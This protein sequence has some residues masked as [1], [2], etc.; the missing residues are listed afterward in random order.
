MIDFLLEIGVEEFPPAILSSTARELSSKVERLLKSKNIFYRS[1]RLIYT[2][3]RMGIIVLGLPRKQ[4]SKI[5]EIQGPPK[6]VAY[7][8]QDNP[9]RMLTGFLKAHNVKIA[10][11]RTKRTKKGEY[12]FIKK[13]VAGILTEDILYED[14]PPLIRSLEFPKTMRW[15]N[16]PERFPRPVRWIVALLDR[17]PLRF[18]FAGV[19]A[20]RYSMPNQHF[21]F[22]SIRLEK[23]REYLN[24]LRHGGVVADPNER[25]KL[26]LK[27]LKQAVA[28]LEGKPVY[29][30]TMIEEI[31]CMTEYPEA[32]VGEFDPKYLELPEE[33]LKTVLRTQGNL[34]W[35]K[36]THKFVSIFSAKKKALQ[37]VKRGY[38]NVIASKLYDALF[39]YHNDRK[40]GLKALV[41]ETK[42]MMWLKDLGSLHDKVLRLNKVVDIFSSVTNLDLVALKR[43]ALLCK[44]DLLSEMIRE[45]DFTMLQGIMGGY[46]ARDAGED[47]KVAHAVQ[48]HYLPNFAGDTLPQTMEGAVLSVVDKI[49]HVVG[50]LMTGYRPSGSYDPLALRRNGYA[51]VT[52]LN[53]HNLHVSVYDVIDSLIAAFEKNCEKEVMHEFIKERLS[54][55]LQDRKYRYDEVKAVTAYWRGDVPDAVLRCAAL[56]KYRGK[57]EFEKLVIGQKRVRNILKGLTR[58]VKIN[59][60]YFVEKDEKRLF[61]AGSTCQEETKELF[62]TRDYTQILDKLLGM[63]PIIDAF[64]DKVLVMCE[65]ERLK[66]NRMAL[67][68]FI[69]QLFLECADFSQIVIEGE[70]EE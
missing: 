61:S 33:V 64:F 45:K 62:K 68:G 70:K 10:Q 54:R 58:K 9:S 13:E 66:Y 2:S 49:D 20:D 42:G 37:H 7:D 4:K 59:P 67:L 11:V 12:I 55:F 36:P 16:S 31:N 44:A 53:A 18:T 26:I 57:K 63:R 24:A 56:K 40:K 19:K 8:D 48:E 65:D 41:Q 27:R 14:I 39:Y 43:A 32:V 5:V 35:L 60:E 30:D 22:K 47:E 15:P 46:Y 3:R 21:S 28:K 25:R 52:V 38:T 17:R 6:K 50:A 51:A 34:I 29:T 23:P 1:T 69:N